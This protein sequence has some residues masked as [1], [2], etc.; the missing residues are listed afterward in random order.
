MDKLVTPPKPPNFYEYNDKLIK[1]PNGSLLKLSGQEDI[2]KVIFEYLLLSATRK[3]RSA[4]LLTNKKFYKWVCEI[5]PYSLIKDISSGN[6]IETISDAIIFGKL[7]HYPKK[8]TS[9]IDTKF[10]LNCNTHNISFKNFKKECF[11]HYPVDFNHIKNNKAIKKT[12]GEIKEFLSHFPNITQINYF[13]QQ[14]IEKNE[15]LFLHINRICI[16]VCSLFKVFPKLK[17]EESKESFFFGYLTNIHQKIVLSL[18]H[19]QNRSLLDRKW[20]AILAKSVVTLIFLRYALNKKYQTIL[21]ANDFID[22]SLTLDKLLEK[23]GKCD[24]F[25]LPSKYKCDPL[26]DKL[27]DSEGFLLYC[28]YQRSDLFMKNISKISNRILSNTELCLQFFKEE[29]INDNGSWNQCRRDLFDAIMN[30]SLRDKKAI[31]E[32]CKMYIFKNQNTSYKTLP[33]TLK[34]DIEC[35]L[36]C[37]RKYKETKGL[38]DSE[39]E[40]SENEEVWGWSESHLLSKDL[41]QNPLIFNACKEIFME[42][43]KTKRSDLSV[44]P[45]EFFCDRECVLAYIKC[46]PEQ[47]KK[48]SLKWTN[49]KEVV[50]AAVKS[51]GAVIKFA[52]KELKNNIDVA[53]EAFKNDKQAYLHISEKLKKNRKFATAI[54]NLHDLTLKYLDDTWKDDEEIVK[55]A[56]MKSHLEYLHASDRVKNIP[57]IAALTV[58]L[59]ESMR[60]EMPK[61]LQENDAFIKAEYDERKKVILIQQ[62]K[63]KSLLKKRKLPSNASTPPNEKKQNT[64]TQSPFEK[65]L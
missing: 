4:L 64:N 43:L 16:A 57:E 56:I 19:C 2:M 47:L 51:K 24:L 34:N 55:I 15:P 53:L 29:N 45:D 27:L 61:E 37:I 13:K 59:N 46:Y 5:D 50:L 22:R 17:I 52:S 40:D 25:G 62:K 9:A 35:I 63:N 20:E 23:W 31:I 41:K 39:S 32:R 28:F 1:I 26:K 21:N 42:D 58:V 49:D 30:R 7:E 65:K 60:T 33:K 3:D 38:T 44:I 14:I 6:K 18:I 54:I 36:H 8:L 10:F 11:I 48:P 12:I